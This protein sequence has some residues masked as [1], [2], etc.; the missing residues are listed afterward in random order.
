[1]KEK[2]KGMWKSWTVWFNGAA[3]TIVAG[4]PLLQD[5]LPQLAPLVSAAVYK[6]VTLFVVL[7]NLF[8]RFKTNK[9]LADK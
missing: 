2:I 3:V 8:L 6:N 5:S 4:L 1:M 9:S 7:V